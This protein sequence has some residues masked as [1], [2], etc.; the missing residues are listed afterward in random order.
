MYQDFNGMKDLSPL[1]IITTEK[2]ITNFAKQ[3]NI[4]LIFF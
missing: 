2:V 3:K 4:S 1:I